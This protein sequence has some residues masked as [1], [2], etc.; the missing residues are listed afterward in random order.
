METEVA[1]VAQEQRLAPVAGAASLAHDVEVVEGLSLVAVPQRRLNLI[2][3]PLLH[4]DL[5]DGVATE[6]PLDH[7]SPSKKY[8]KIPCC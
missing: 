3:A 5:S 2:G 4:P 6:T 8:L 7:Y 1:A